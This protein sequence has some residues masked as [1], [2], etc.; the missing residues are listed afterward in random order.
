MIFYSR[1]KHVRT[2]GYRGNL[3][4]IFWRGGANLLCKIWY[5]VCCERVVQFVFQVTFTMY[6]RVSGLLTPN[7]TFVW[8]TKMSVY[9]FPTAQPKDMTFTSHSC[10]YDVRHRFSSHIQVL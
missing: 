6:V 4:I 10:Q 9:L 8:F 3:Y 1:L 5:F 7:F 2:V